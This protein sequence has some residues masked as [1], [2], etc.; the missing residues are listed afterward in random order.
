LRQC[1]PE[2]YGLIAR[3]RNIGEAPAPE[4]VPVYFYKGDPDMGG[5]LLGTGV[6]TQTLYPAEAEDV[7]LLLPDASEDIK[8][9]SA[10][11]WIVVDDP[12]PDHPWHECREDNNRT[13]GS[14]RCHVPG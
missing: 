10:V 14:G 3:V 13:S 7:L 8:D 6:T 2:D 11:I 12:M 5:E 1:P 4:G 9:G